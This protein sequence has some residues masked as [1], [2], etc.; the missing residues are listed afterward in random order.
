MESPRLRWIAALLT[1]GMLAA[2]QPP[3]LLW[4][5]LPLGVAA[6]FILWRKA[7]TARRAFWTG[8]LAGTAYFTGTLFWIVEPF[9]V[10]PEKF[11]WMI[12]IALPALAGGLA[13]F[14]G[15]ALAVARRIGRAEWAE[16][17]AFAACWMIAEALRG[18]VLTG[19]PWAQPGYSLV[20]VPPI[21]MAAH[22][23][24]HGVTF[25]ALL[26]GA[27]L[28]AAL[29]GRRMAPRVVFAML[30]VC[31]GGGSW[32]AGAARLAVETP[33][34]AAPVMVGLVQPN[35]P[36]SE[37][38]HP[39][40]RDAQLADLLEK[41]A[42]LSEQ[43]ADVVIWPEAATPFPLAEM[44]DLRE[45]IAARLR[46]EGVLLAGG[47]RVEGRGTASQRV[48][49]SLIAV[50]GDGALLSTYDKQH[51]VP[52]GEYVPF[53]AVLT[54]LGVR[55]VI[56]LP[57]GFTS[58]AAQ[59]R[60]LEVGGLPPFG[61][62]I[63]YEAIFPHEVLDRGAEVDWL[64]HV[65]NDAWFGRIAGPQQHLAQTRVR[66]IERGVPV[67]RAANTGVSAM[68]DAKGQIVSVLTLNTP[69]TFIVGLPPVV[70]STLYSL[71]EELGF[72]LMLLGVLI[73]ITLISRR[74]DV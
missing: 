60:A 43:G 32:I 47:I 19:F 1:G 38:W 57:G 65:T 48:Y 24:I 66:A 42:S 2:S 73:S 20:D 69:G 45:A 37:K 71:F 9:L 58:G 4:W 52:F 18:F 6:L 68:I 62:M 12:P 33:A 61:A 70:D 46:P 34:R 51:L 50:G 16:P 22:I 59:N 64:V 13:L 29:I 74:C 63:C 17:L 28:G 15:V 67:A 3:L 49:N 5:L 14:W 26:V 27:F 11:A 31:I 36:Q 54:R 35:V 7:E 55:A 8:W 72:I 56:S 21:Q 30:A 25:L 41:T 53:D 10:E 40:L 39:D 44:P 23:G